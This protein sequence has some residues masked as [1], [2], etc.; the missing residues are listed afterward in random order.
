MADE[1]PKE[2]EGEKKQSSQKPILFIGL[3]VFNLVVVIGVAYMLYSWKKHEEAQTTI[4]D[5][6]E[7]EHAEQEHDKLEEEELLGLSVPLETFLVNLAGVRG[8]RLLKVTMSLEV[9][10]VDVQ[11]EVEKRKAEIRDTI[12]IL[13]SSKSFDQVSSRDGKDFLR[14][15]V[16]DTLNSFLTK[17]KVKS[18]LFTEFF[19]N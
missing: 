9:D 16:R 11:N 3:A 8:G 14:E 18:V 5:V 19:Y 7:G 2:N 13:L 12:L 10:G 6:V 4:Q 15:E 1:K 17:G